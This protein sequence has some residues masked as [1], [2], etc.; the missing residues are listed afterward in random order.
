[1]LHLVKHSRVDRRVKRVK[2]PGGVPTRPAGGSGCSRPVGGAR[3][4]LLH[5]TE[6]ETTSSSDPAL[7][8]RLALPF[9]VK[10]PEVLR[11][12]ERLVL[13]C[14]EA[15]VFKFA[16]FGGECTRSAHFSATLTSEISHFIQKRSVLLL[17]Y[18]QVVSH[19]ICVK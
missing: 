15:D 4:T 5:R 7:R 19:V 11:F 2:T 14:I 6:N 13:G 16:E 18:M 17:K 8:C 3:C 12:L 10:S 9:S 1:M